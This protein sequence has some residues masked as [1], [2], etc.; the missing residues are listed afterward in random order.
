[1]RK[2]IEDNF[3]DNI[4][5]ENNLKEKSIELSNKTKEYW[6]SLDNCLTTINFEDVYLYIHS[7]LKNHFKEV[8]YR[9]VAPYSA[10]STSKNLTIVNSTIAPYI[11]NISPWREY[12]FKDIIIQPCVRL[13]SINK[14][15]WLLYDQSHSLIFNMWWVVTTE[16]T[17]SEFIWQWIDFLSK[18][19]DKNRLYFTY[20][21]NESLKEWLINAWVDSWRIFKVSKNTD[22]FKINWQ[23]DIPWPSWSGI[24]AFY[25]IF[26]WKKVSNIKDFDRLKEFLNIIH[27][28][29]YFDGVEYIN[30]ET[31]VSE[32]GFWIERLASLIHIDKYIIKKNYLDLYN[33]LYNKKNNSIEGEE[34]VLKSVSDYLITSIYLLDQWILPES[35]KSWYILRKL[36]RLI[37]LH[38]FKIWIS[39]KNIIE[40][41]PSEHK[42][43]VLKE[44]KIFTQMLYATARNLG[45]LNPQSFP[46]EKLIYFHETLWI[47][48]EI[49]NLFVYNRIHFSE[50]LK[51]W[52]K[53]KD[54][55]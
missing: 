15:N 50:L 38:S 55:E 22:V 30:L 3:E 8:L 33:Q 35:K 24:T 32:I 43:I 45:E 37:L 18:I 7:E 53:E 14:E 4:K 29:S 1:M 48:L 6:S 52:E 5:Q 47:P 19:I 41:Y 11:P 49:S 31:P 26:P 2:K 40:Q 25:D 54:N 27:I 12:S 46:G 44:I 39:S 23:Y 17:L 20:W 42:D 13:K 34:L 9:E 28:D 21:N 10:L 36:I 51:N 16:F